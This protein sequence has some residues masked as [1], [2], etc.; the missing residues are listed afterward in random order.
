MER[1]IIPDEF[2]SDH[3]MVRLYSQYE[4]LI[5]EFWNAYN[6]H[7]KVEKKASEAMELKKDIKKM[8]TDTAKLKELV[9]SQKEKVSAIPNSS[10]LLVLA[11]DYHDAITQR[12]N[13]EEQVFTTFFCVLCRLKLFF[14][15]KNPEESDRSNRK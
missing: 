11:K 12:S 10:S 3:D 15:V 8:E 7:K 6:E 5:E 13:L 1:I 4:K 14:L 9:E 2:K